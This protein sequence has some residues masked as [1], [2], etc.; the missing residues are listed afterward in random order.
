MESQYIYFIAASLHEHVVAGGAEVTEV[1]LL[2]VL[3][4]VNVLAQSYLLIFFTSRTLFAR[5]CCMYVKD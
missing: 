1:C 5:F 4:S 3:A 2:A